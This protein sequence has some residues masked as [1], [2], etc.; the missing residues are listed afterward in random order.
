M[1]YALIVA[2]FVAGFGLGGFL[3]VFAQKWLTG[4]Q[5]QQM[6]SDPGMVGLMESFELRRREED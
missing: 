3:M 2:V 5:M 1:I 6:M 4:R